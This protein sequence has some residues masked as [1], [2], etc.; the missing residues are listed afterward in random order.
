VSLNYFGPVAW[1]QINGPVL[2]GQPIQISWNVAAIG[3]VTGN[4]VATITSSGNK[5]L[6]TSKPIPAVDTTHSSPFRQGLIGSGSA[7]E[8]D[9]SLQF[10]P[11][12]PVAQ[13][14]YAI[15]TQTLTLSV[16]GSGTDCT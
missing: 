11:T 13:G 14:L 16:T 15:G 7:G 1:L 3:Q 5:V 8:S 2:P 12:Q 10:D 4:F 9:V 6:Y